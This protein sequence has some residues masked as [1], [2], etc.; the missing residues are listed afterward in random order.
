MYDRMEFDEI[1]HG[2]A[3]CYENY[4]EF[5]PSKN[6]TQSKRYTSPIE[7]KT[8][9]KDTGLQLSEGVLLL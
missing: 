5:F 4:R 3:D 1:P 8:D 7:L 2:Y 9:N 6:L